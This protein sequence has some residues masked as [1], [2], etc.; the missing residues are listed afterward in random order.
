MDRAAHLVHQ[1]L[2][3][4]GQ[5]PLAVRRLNLNDAIED[6]LDLIKTSL[7]AA[8]SLELDLLAG[9]GNIEVIQC[10]FSRSS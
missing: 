8:V 3:Y 1:M 5:G 4:S 7:T 9:L 10:R 6:I 2:A